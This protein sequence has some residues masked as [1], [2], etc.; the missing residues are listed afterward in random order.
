MT[1]FYFLAVHFD[2]Y[3]DSTAVQ[4]TIVSL[5][6]IFGSSSIYHCYPQHMLNDFK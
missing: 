3:C 2:K 1:D 4:T 5:E 6:T